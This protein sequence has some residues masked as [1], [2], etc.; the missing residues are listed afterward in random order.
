MV[1]NMTPLIYIVNF[2]ISLYS[3]GETRSIRFLHR[4]PNDVPIYDITINLE[5][6]SVRS[7]HS[8]FEYV[9]V[10]NEKTFNEVESYVVK[11]DTHLQKFEKEDEYN[12][13]IERIKGQDTIFYLLSGQKSSIKYFGKLRS[14]VRDKTSKSEALITQLDVLMDRIEKKNTWKK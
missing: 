7:D 13:R 14:D 2:L 9:V 6:G 10:V 12:F 5:D 3:S 8:F 4:G 1:T 11:E